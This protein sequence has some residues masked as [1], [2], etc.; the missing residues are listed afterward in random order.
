MKGDNMIINKEK[1]K[2]DYIRK[3][4]FKNADMVGSNLGAIAVPLTGG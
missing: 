2:I 3:V 1:S 4:T